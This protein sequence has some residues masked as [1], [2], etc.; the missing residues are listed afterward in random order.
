MPEQ[1]KVLSELLQFYLFCL[2]GDLT[3]PHPVS[4]MAV[5]VGSPTMTGFQDVIRNILAIFRS[6]L[7]WHL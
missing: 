4:Y 3:L 2:E 1:D 7:T 6:L 5:Q